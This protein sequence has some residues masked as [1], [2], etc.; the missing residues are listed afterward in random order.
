MWSPTCKN[1]RGQV[2]RYEILSLPQVAGQDVL[3]GR[4]AA[5]LREGRRPRRGNQQQRGGRKGERS[6]DTVAV[7]GGQRRGSAGWQLD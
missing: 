3:Q 2:P 1:L 7:G 5:Q 6:R 4:Q